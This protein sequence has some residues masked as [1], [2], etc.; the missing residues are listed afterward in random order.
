[1]SIRRVTFVVGVSAASAPPKPKESDMTTTRTTTTASPAT[2]STGPSLRRTT[3]VVGAAGA[4]VTTLAAAALHAA[5]VP[6]AVDGEMI[7]LA[8]FAQMTFLGAVI[9]G[10]IVAVLN[11]RSRAPRRRFVQTALA[12]TALTCV[13]SAVLPPDVATKAA[14]VA[15]HLLAAAIIVPRLV[16]HAHA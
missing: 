9:G 11:R 15:L 14:L 3:L 6:L 4:V 1:M 16:R 7:P 12:L 5:G 10:L 2:T 8:G 13:P